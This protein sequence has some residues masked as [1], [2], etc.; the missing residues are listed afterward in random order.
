MAAIA[1]DDAW[2]EQCVIAITKLDGSDV[3]FAA[4]TETV[5]FDIGEKDIEGLPITNGGRITKWT[6][7]GDS[8]ITFEAYPLQ[9]GT[10]SGAEGTGF[11]DLLHEMD[12]VAPIRVTNSR[13][14]DKYRVLVIWTND[15]S[16]TTGQAITTD[17][18]SALR[19]GMADGYFTSVKPSFTDGIQK[20]TVVFKT[21]A[22]DK[23]GDSN[24]MV[25]SC[26]GASETDILPVIAAY[27]TGT[28]PAS[29]AKFA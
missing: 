10:A 12:A 14:R 5:D 18:H 9:A 3:Q 28:A 22:F 25:E 27:T 20:W 19:I 2:M 29:N 16:V 1:V 8:S 11:F 23:K 13:V 15:A 26:A 4:M 21:A 17:T 6:P 24:V 7:E